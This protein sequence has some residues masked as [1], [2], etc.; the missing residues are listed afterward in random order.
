MVFLRLTL[1]LYLV[2]IIVFIFGLVSELFVF[3]LSQF[4]R[5]FHLTL[6]HASTAFLQH[7]C[8]DSNDL[9]DYKADC[10]RQ[11]TVL[12]LAGAIAMRTKPYL[13][14]ENLNGKMR[15]I[16]SFFC[17]CHISTESRIFPSR[18][19]P[20]TVSLTNALCNKSGVSCVCVCIEGEAK[21]QFTTLKR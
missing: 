20:D 6:N 5:L 7:L 12:W 17:I 2:D 18:N 21:E 3:V 10:A 11:K 16:D 9:S 4:F 8:L 13:V 1:I 14:M 15:S 19:D